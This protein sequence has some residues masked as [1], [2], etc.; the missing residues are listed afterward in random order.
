[1]YALVRC[2][3][4]K[5]KTI[6]QGIVKPSSTIR[7]SLFSPFHSESPSTDIKPFGSLRP[8]NSGVQV[9]VGPVVPENFFV[10]IYIYISLDHKTGKELTF[11]VTDMIIK[12]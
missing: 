2:K 9:L 5:C 1:M 7:K 3:I 4:V 8:V 12:I 6:K 11:T 10:Y